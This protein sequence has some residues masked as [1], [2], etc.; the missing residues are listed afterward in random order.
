[1]NIK[2]TAKSIETMKWE[3]GETTVR[4]EE[5]MCKW[6]RR[7]I[8]TVTAPTSI[9]HRPP[10]WNEQRLLLPNETN[11]NDRCRRPRKSL[12]QVWDPWRVGEGNVTIFFLFIN[13]RF[14]HVGLMFHPILV[15][16]LWSTPQYVLLPCLLL[17][18]VYR[19]HFD[20]CIS[21]MLLTCLPFTYLLH[22]MQAWPI[23]I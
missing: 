17:T 4:R 5:N 3:R 9:S 22:A 20:A 14:S 18:H 16:P 15:S 23:R 19:L 1:M 8:V 21:Y 12:H 2:H 7:K 6:D 13:V 11:A 10:S